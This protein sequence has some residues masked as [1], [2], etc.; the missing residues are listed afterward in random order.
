MSNTPKSNRRSGS[1][2]QGNGPESP[3]TSDTTKTVDTPDMS[4]TLE[5]R[6]EELVTSTHPVEVGAVRVRR[7][8][9]AVPAHLEVEA[10]RDEVELER[11]PM[12]EEVS[13]RVQPWDDQGVTVIPIYEEQLVVVKRLILKEHVRVRPVRRTET[14]LVDDTVLSERLVVEDPDETGKVREMYPTDR[15]PED[16]KSSGNLLERAMQKALD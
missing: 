5:L 14:R 16:K 1:S 2:R 15:E 4:R 7:D 11:V 10:F 12:G 3:A 9:E 6:E 8:V 13:E